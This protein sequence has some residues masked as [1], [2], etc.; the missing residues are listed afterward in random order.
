[1]KAKENERILKIARGE[2]QGLLD[3][4][5]S[6]YLIKKHRGLKMWDNIFNVLNKKKNSVS[7][8]LYIVQIHHS[9]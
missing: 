4:N 6:Q 2:L 8:E 3:V 9:K 1:M 5:H 7:P